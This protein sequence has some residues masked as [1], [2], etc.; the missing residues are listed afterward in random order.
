MIAGASFFDY[1]LATYDT[2]KSFREGEQHSEKQ[3]LTPLDLLTK[4]LPEI[5]KAHGSADSFAELVHNLADPTSLLT[6][7][8][9]IFK[10]ALTGTLT[11]RNRIIPS[12]FVIQKV[13]IP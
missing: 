7:D 9:N 2:H 11:P 12:T 5:M 8:P 13:T 10:A 4:P 3:K 6:F 1:I